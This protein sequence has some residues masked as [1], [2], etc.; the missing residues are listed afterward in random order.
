[1][2]LKSILKHVAIGQMLPPQL[3]DNGAF[4]DNTYFDSAGCAGVLVLLTI[5][6]TDIAM[7]S[8]SASTPPYLEECD[9][10][11]GTFTKITGSDLAAVVSATDDNKTIG[12]FVDRTKTRKRYLR[13]NAPTAGDGSTGVNAAAIAIGFPENEIPI[14]AAAMGLKELVQV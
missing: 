2:D 1:M 6:T 5:G 7:G 10:T 9:T 11:N 4:A 14:T 13:I 3:K 12:W 8:T